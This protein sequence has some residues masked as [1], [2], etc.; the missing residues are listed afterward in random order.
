MTESDEP[1]EAE[2][3]RRILAGEVDL[4]RHLV[5]S[6]KDVVFGIV[7][8]QTADFSTAEDLTQEAF[9]KA[10]QNLQS[11]RSDSK[12]STWLVR[13]ALNHT[14][15]YFNSKSFK[16]RKRTETFEVSKHDMKDSQ[17]EQQQLLKERYGHFQLCL[18]KLKPAL[19]DVVTLCGL[20]GR[21]YEDVAVVVDIPVGTVRSRLNKARLVLRD[22]MERAANA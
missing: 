16:Q 10:F 17:I 20:E 4:Y 18:A 1:S 22:C 6:Y 8:R 19:R 9:V 15:S 5:S 14:S 11:F 7:M 12:F 2:L 3:I 13:I 21:S